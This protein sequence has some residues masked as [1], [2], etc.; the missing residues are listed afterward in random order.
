VLK[1]YTALLKSPQ[2][3]KTMLVITYDEHGGFFDHVLPPAARDDK[4]AFRTYGVRVPSLVVSPF[5]ARGSVSNVVYDHTSIIKTILLRFCSDANGQ[6]PDM[7]QRVQFANH[8]GA[9]LTLPKAR[10][11]TNPAAYQYVVDRIT[12]WRSAVFRSRILMEPL[13]TPADPLELN[14]LQQQVLAAKKVARAK[15]LKE[16]QP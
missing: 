1:L 15:G 4:P 3:S 9:T 14:D 16:G 12:S 11:P 10:K 7:G 13:T 6:I 2:W 8:L 5:T